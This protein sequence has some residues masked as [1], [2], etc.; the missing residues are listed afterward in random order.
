MDL[1][2]KKTFLI[3]Y[4][5]TVSFGN[6]FQWKSSILLLESGNVGIVLFFKKKQNTIYYKKIF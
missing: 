3:L 5:L 6:E 4:L 2:D 1:F